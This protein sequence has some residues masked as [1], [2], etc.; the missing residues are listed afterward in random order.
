MKFFVKIVIWT[1]ALVVTEINRDLFT[2]KKLK[3]IDNYSLYK[4]LF[5]LLY[6]RNKINIFENVESFKYKLVIFSW[7]Y[8]QEMWLL[9]CLGKGKIN[10][11]S[12]YYITK[13][14]NLNN[15]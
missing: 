5:L 4:Y 1:L 7:F 12:I 3:D 11:F 14:N 9:R 6:F 8:K 10:I 15:F 2:K 13:K